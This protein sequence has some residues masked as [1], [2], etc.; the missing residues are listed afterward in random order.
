MTFPVAYVLIVGGVCACAPLFKR[1]SN[2]LGRLLSLA[3]FFVGVAVI[4]IAADTAL[5]LNFLASR[6]TSPSTADQ[7][8]ASPYLKYYLPLLIVLGLLLFSRPIRN[9]RWASLIALGAGLLAPAYLRTLLPSLS[10][11]L[12]AVVFI[13]AALVVY[14]LLKF[15]EDI[16]QFIGS[17]LAFPPIAVGIGLVAIYFGAVMATLP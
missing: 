2:A 16:F 15:V 3:G 4:I 1:V 14:M 10:P 12:L 11:S 13:I 17:V 5:G 9:I 6:F 8:A 7:I